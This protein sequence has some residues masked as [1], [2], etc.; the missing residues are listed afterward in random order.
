MSPTQAIVTLRPLRSAAVLDAA[1][2]VVAGA[3]DCPAVIARRAG[4]IA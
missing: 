4:G 3:V 2:V 1:A